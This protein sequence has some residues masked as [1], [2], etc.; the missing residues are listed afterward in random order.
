MKTIDA[1]KTKLSIYPAEFAR[2]RASQPA[3]APFETPDAL[4]TALSLSSSATAPERDAL[5]LALVA[6]H[7][8]KAHPVWSSI[9]LAAYEPMLCGVWKR[10]LDKRDAQARL[11]LAFL[12]VIAK[13]DVDDPPSLVAL[14]L[15]HAVERS[16]FGSTAEAAIE[17]QR[18]SLS[19]ARKEPHPDSPDARI[20]LNDEMRRLERELARLFDDEAPLVLQVLV[21]ART[22]RV[23]LEAF[24]EERH[25][26]LTP[27]ARALLYQRLERHRRVALAHLERQFGANAFPSVF[28][29]A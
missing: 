11:V 5:T 28:L 15:R 4:L 9:L 26:D 16:V 18:L 14:H 13:L 12:E 6:E 25:G 27:R 1:L 7:Q 17:P 21:H 19:E 10:A 2:G 24:I 22:G 29:A 8:R 20:A 3:L 23:P